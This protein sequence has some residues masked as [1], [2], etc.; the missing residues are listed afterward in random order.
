M[1]MSE[2]AFM[3]AFVYAVS[4]ERRKNLTQLNFVG[5]ILHEEKRN[6]LHRVLFHIFV[7]MKTSIEILCSMKRIFFRFV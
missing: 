7:Q 4:C 3:Y 1:S 6:M 2:R 5:T